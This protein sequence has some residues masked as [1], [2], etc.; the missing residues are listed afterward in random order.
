MPTTVTLMYQWVSISS[1]QSV[2][3]KY[4][5]IINYYN[6]REKPI[7]ITIINK[8]KPKKRKTFNAKIIDQKFCFEKLEY[9]HNIYI[10][11]H[12]Q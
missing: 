6:N 4:H 2:K 7:S 11:I 1:L 5:V 8:D 10:V 3:K 9:K 12:E